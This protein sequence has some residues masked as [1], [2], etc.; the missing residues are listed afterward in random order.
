MT[1]LGGVLAVLAMLSGLVR[2]LTQLAVSPSGLTALA[3]VGAAVL[4]GRPFPHVESPWR[5]GGRRVLPCLRADR[6]PHARPR[7]P[8]R[9]RRDHR[10]HDGGP[11]PAHAAE[12]ARPA[13]AGRPGPAGPSAAGLA[14]AAR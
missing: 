11:A 7:R 4:A 2:D 1:A 8:G 13:R 6:C 12:P 5:P 3:L 9:R 10:L 14:P